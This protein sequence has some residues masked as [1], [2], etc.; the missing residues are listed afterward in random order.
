MD[1][2]NEL[3]ERE[4]LELVRMDGALRTL[5]L[6][7][8]EDMSKRSAQLSLQRLTALGYPEE[9]SYQG[10]CIGDSVGTCLDALSW[11]IEARRILLHP[12]VNLVGI[13][14]EVRTDQITLVLTLSHM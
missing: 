2:I 3:R 14:S 8:L 5:G 7:P 10:L 13:T 4:G 6:L 1:M 9:R 12:D 11:D